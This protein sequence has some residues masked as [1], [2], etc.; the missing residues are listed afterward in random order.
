MKKE[1]K[2]YKNKLDVEDLENE[3]A[4]S[5]NAINFNTLVTPS[6]NANNSSNDPPGNAAA[7]NNAA[8]QNGNANTVVPVNET[9]TNQLSQNKN[10]NSNINSNNAS[11]SNAPPVIKK[12]ARLSLRPG[13][14]K[15]GTKKKKLLK[16]EENNMML[17]QEGMDHNQDNMGMDNNAMNMAIMI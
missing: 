5:A 1:E 17:S 12:P 11:S 13:L 9:R 3:R 16:S 7:S 2:K 15:K 4:L 14:K 10:I 8:A 6:S